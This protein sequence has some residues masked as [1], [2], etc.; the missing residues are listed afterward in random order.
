MLRPDGAVCGWLFLS[1]AFT[2]EGGLRRHGVEATTS[3]R[4]KF[5][6]K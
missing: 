5:L 4:S 1:P 2:E 6:F 3:P